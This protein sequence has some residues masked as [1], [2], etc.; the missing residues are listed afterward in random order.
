ME[1]V[2][3]LNLKENITLMS[4]INLK[5]N[6]DRFSA[7]LLDEARLFCDFC[8]DK[9]ILVEAFIDDAIKAKIVVEGKEK[10]FIGNKPNGDDLNVKRLTKRFL[11]VSLYDYLSQLSGRTL[12]WGSLTGV[13]PTKLAYDY[14][15]LGGSID[16]VAKYLVDVFR[17]SE[18]K[19]NTISR[20][21]KAQQRVIKERNN[22]VNL[23][24]HVPFCDGRCYYCSFPSADVNKN[25]TLLLPYAVEKVVSIIKAQGKEILSVYVGGGTPSVLTP[26]MIE[27]ILKPIKNENCEF[28][29][30]AGRPDSINEEKLS[31]LKNNGVTRLCVNPQTLNNRT[32]EII[33]RKHTAE[34]FYRAYEL[35]KS[36]GFDVNTDV[37]AGLEGEDLTDFKYT[38]DGIFELLPENVTIHTLSKKR[39]SVIADKDMR[40][41]CDDIE[42]MTDYAYDKLVSRYEPYYL[43]R[44]KNMV[45]NLENVGFAIE[46]KQCINNITVMEETVSVYACGAGSISKII[47]SGKINRHASVKDVKLYIDEFDKRLTEKIK[48]LSE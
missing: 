37:I 44:Q 11:K 26:E 35:A 45:G 17:V 8:A 27:R 16:D 9:E 25:K 33:G 15:K 4:E 10:V 36:F 14:L 24:L 7:D 48:F 47:Q 5:T 42:K 1:R 3:R 34:S 40:L 41:F 29:F 39:G 19:A 22:C 18:R 31:A 23:Y 6:I 32:L 38:V 20:I 21:I 28:T 12:P 43:Y 2:R 46:G 13:R 30:E